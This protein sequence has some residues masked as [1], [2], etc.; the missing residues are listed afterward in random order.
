MTENNSAEHDFFGE[1]LGLGF[2]HQH[3]G[4]GTG[5]DEV[6]LRNLELAQGRAQ[7]IL[8]VDVTNTSR[9]DRPIERHA[10]DRQRGG[11]ADQRG[12]IGVNFRIQRHHGSDDLDFVVEIIREQRANRTIDQAAG[13]RFLVGGTAFALQE[14]AGNSTSSVSFFLIIDRHREEILAWLARFRSHS[15]H[16]N[17]SL[18]HRDQYGAAS[19]AGNFACFDGDLMVSVGKGLF[20]D[21]KHIFLSLSSQ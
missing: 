5:D 14:A 2:N 13:Q 19:L 20:H 6:K 18:L 16:Q 15:A 21:I 7:N 8:A 12:N 9:T 10:G 17:D 1:L 11:S 3:G 4:F